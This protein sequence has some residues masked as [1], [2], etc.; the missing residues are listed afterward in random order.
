[1]R[2][3]LGVACCGMYSS[4][5]WYC[6]LWRHTRDCHPSAWQSIR[7]ALQSARGQTLAF[8]PATSHQAKYLHFGL[9]GKHKWKHGLLTTV[10][11]WIDCWPQDSQGS[12]PEMGD[13]SPLGIDLGIPSPRSS[14]SFWAG[15]LAGACD[16]TCP[17]LQL[18]CC[19]A[20]SGVFMLALIVW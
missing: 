10:C 6:V 3:S 13:L 12:L 8:G 9:H 2:A 15:I 20:P 7:S 17:K 4:C 1:M 11:I 16:R 18:F 5:G 14:A 19:G